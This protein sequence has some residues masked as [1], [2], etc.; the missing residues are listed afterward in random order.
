MPTKFKQIPPPDDRRSVSTWSLLLAGGVVL[1][2]VTGRWTLL[3]AILGLALLITVHEF[4]HFIAAKAFGMQVE[5]FY[6]GF[7]PAAFKKRRGETEY[8]VG[9]IPLGGFCKIS[10]MTPEEEVPEGTGD[11]VYYKAPVWKRNLTIFAGPFMNFVAAVVILFAFLMVQGT[12]TATLR[13]DEVVAGTPAAAAG[14]KAGDTVVGADG[15]RWSEWQQ[16]SEYFRDNPGKTIELTYVPAG[17]SGAGTSAEKTVSVTLAE[18]PDAPGQ[19]YLGVRAGTKSENP[20]VA[21]AA[22]LS[23]VGLKDVTWGVFYGIYLLASGAID[24]T[25]PEGAVGPVGII[26]VSGDAVR[27][28]WYPILLAFLSANL[29]IINLLPILPF[30]GGHI[31]FNTVERIRGRRMNPRVLER[32]VAFG[33]TLLILLFVL[34]TF[35]DFRR[36]FG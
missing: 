9:I 36:I 30:D 8:G 21:R 5:K 3:V 25:G 18:H 1:A 10:G 11:R 35:N 19:G 14:L 2:L 32:V 4:G 26:D 6:V 24:V 23:L 33:V 31:F 29:G 16:A 34:L 15:H 27:Q 13:L 12:T 28:G 7:P 22:W 17:A 20:G